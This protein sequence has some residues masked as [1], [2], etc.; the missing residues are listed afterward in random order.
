MTGTPNASIPWDVSRLNIAYYDQGWLNGE[1]VLHWG[2]V[3]LIKG[4]SRHLNRFR[5]V[6]MRALLRSGCCDDKV[7]HLVVDLFQVDAKG[8][9]HRLYVIKAGDMILASQDV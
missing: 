5:S 6:G 8:E 4:F 1:L 3:V 2:D 7:E 9:P